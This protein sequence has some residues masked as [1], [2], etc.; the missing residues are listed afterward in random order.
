MLVNNTLDLQNI[1]TN[2]AGTYALGSNLDASSFGNFTP[3]GNAAN[4]F[5]GVFDGRGN[6][7]SNLSV[8][9]TDANLGLFGVNNGAIRTVGLVNATITADGPEIVGGVA[10]TNTGTIF[11]SFCQRSSQWIYRRGTRW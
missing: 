3:I 5:T 10:G 4:P 8:E 7:I 9:G 6:I 2:K 11:S 1:N